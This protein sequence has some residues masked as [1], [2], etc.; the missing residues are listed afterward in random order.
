MSVQQYPK[1]LKKTM[2]YPHCLQGSNDQK[3]PICFNFGQYT[4]KTR[5][6]YKTLIIA[7][8]LFMHPLVCFQSFQGLSLLETNKT[9]QMPSRSSLRSQ[10]LWRVFVLRAQRVSQTGIMVRVASSPKQLWC[11]THCTHNSDGI[12][13]EDFLSSYLAKSCAKWA[14]L[15]GS[16]T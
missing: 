6:G 11:C 2:L 10:W 16:E 15:S 13:S 12:S 5:A 3:E 7:I 8:S 14:W 9:V 4:Y 1:F